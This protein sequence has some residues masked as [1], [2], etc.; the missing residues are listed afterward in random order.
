MK[1]KIVCIVL[2]VYVMSVYSM[3]KEMPADQNQTREPF[4]NR[5]VMIQRYMH[6]LE[7]GES[8]PSQFNWNKLTINDSEHGSKEP[9]GKAKL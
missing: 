7:S 5:I 1:V 2:V 9:C 6:L 4:R 8:L 3:K